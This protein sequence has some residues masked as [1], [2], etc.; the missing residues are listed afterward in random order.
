MNNNSMQMLMDALTRSQQSMPSMRPSPYDMSNAYQQGSTSDR[1][2][3]KDV[4]PQG[5]I[6]K[7]GMLLA[8]NATQS[9]MKGGGMFGGSG[10]S[11]MA[12][13]GGAG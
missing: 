1:D 10:G 5:A 11:S 2:T 12:A 6:A 9:V 8:P 13:K 7:M 4:A 3:S